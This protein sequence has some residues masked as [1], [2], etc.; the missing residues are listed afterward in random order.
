MVIP[1]QDGVIWLPECAST[2]DEAWLRAADPAVKAV[3]A[4]RQT[5][6]RGRRGRAWTSPP[7]SG[8]Y[9]TWLA[10]P[11][12]PASDGGALPLLAAVAVAELATRAGAKPWLKWPND[13]WVG[14]GKLAGI[15][16]E[17]RTDGA[18]W[19]AVVGVGLNLRTP[20]DGW[21]AGVPAVA[22]DAVAPDVPEPHAAAKDLLQRLARWQAKVEADG[23]APLIEA[24]GQWA[25]PEGTV[26][27]QAG[28][29]GAFLGLAEDGALRLRDAEGAEILIRT[30]EVHLVEAAPNPEE[31]L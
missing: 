24:W 29:R 6:G 3:V 18:A 31:P 28:H 5:A 13:V 25:P 16:T 7:G 26:F 1:D 8:L 12:F 4:H 23:F 21:P 22:L 27:E 9:L 11:G 20:K 15:L 30:G 10:R 19:A 2:N 17:A 14:D